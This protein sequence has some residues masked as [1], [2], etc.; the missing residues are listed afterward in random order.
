VVGK[1][2]DE[3]LCEG[4]IFLLYAARRHGDWN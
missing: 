1:S 3:D 2:T 4:S